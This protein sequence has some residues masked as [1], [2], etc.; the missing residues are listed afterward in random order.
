[1]SQI[2]RQNNLFAGEDFLKVFR[3]FKQ[4]NFTAYDYDTIRSALVDYIKEQFPED[5]NDYIESSEFIAII[6]LLSYLGTSLAFR[7]ELNSRENFL[8]TAERRESIIRLARML[9]YSPSRNQCARGLLKVFGV[10]TNEP[11][12][13]SMGNNLQ[14]TLVFWDDANNPNA[15]EQF[16]T[17]LNSSFVA[18]NPFGRPFKSG[19]IGSINTDLYQMNNSGLASIVYGAAVTLAD[20]SF[21]LEIVNPDF[22]DG[23]TFVERNPDPAN[24]FH[25]IYRN[26][27]NGLASNNTGFFMHFRQGKLENRDFQLDFPVENR[28]LPIDVN[29]I[30]NTDVYVQQI[31]DDGS[32][33]DHWD[34]VP[35]ISGSNI[36]FN[37]MDLSD[38][39]IY[40]VIT[41]TNDRIKLRFADGNFGE[42]P[43]GVFRAWY[44]KSANSYLTIRPENASNIQV[45]IPYVGRTGRTYFL[46]MYIGL[47]DTVNNSA[48]SETDE[49]I[50]I[51][52][53]QV[54][55]TQNRMVNAEDYNVFPLNKGNEIT[56]IHALNRTYSGHSRYISI[57]DPTGT[58]QNL[59][60]FGEDGY[61]YKEEEPDRLTVDVDNSTDFTSMIT[62]TLRQFLDNSR[63]T[64]WFY[65]I[66]YQ[67]FKELHPNDLTFINELIRWKTLPERAVGEQG[68]FLNPN[69]P[70]NLT[71]EQYILEALSLS[72]GNYSY[73]EPGAYLRFVN[74]NNPSELITAS[75]LSAINAGLPT[76]PDITQVGPVILS[77][78]IDNLWLLNDVLPA[79]RKDFDVVELSEIMAQI[80]LQTD[81]GLGYDA[82]QGLWYV[83]PPATIDLNSDFD[84]TTRGTS[85]DSSWVVYIDYEPSAGATPAS[86]TFVTRGIRYVFGSTQSVRFFFSPEQKAIDVQTGKSL[87]D[88]IDVLSI[89]NRADT[90]IWSYNSGSAVWVFNGLTIS[91]GQQMIMLRGRDNN[92]S[93]VQILHRNTISSVDYGSAFYN[94]EYGR[95]NFINGYVPVEGDV[96]EITYLDAT[97][98]GT[99]ISFD[100]SESFI[101]EDGHLDQTKVEIRPTDTDEDGVPDY[102]LSFTDIVNIDSDVIYFERFTDFD[103]YQYFRPWVTG[104]VDATVNAIVNGSA[105]TVNGFSVS[106]TGLY[107]FTD[108]A[109]LHAF[110]DS[111]ADITPLNTQEIFAQVLEGKIAHLLD[112][113]QFVVIPRVIATVALLS[114]QNNYDN[115]EV[116]NDYK[117]EIGRSYNLNTFETVDPFIFKWKHFAPRENRIDP[118]PSNI[119]DI[120]LLTS[121]YY[122]EVQKWKED[123]LGVDEFPEMPSSEDLAV[124]FG[125][126][127]EYKMISDE[128]I[129]KPAKYKI[130]FGTQAEPELRATFKVVKIP[131]VPVSDNEIKSRIVQAI[132]QYFDINNWD[133]GESFYYTELS[134]YIHQ[135][136]ANLV[137]TIVIVPTKEESQF[138]DLFQIKAEPD[139]LFI[140]TATVSNIQVVSS[141]TDYNLRT[142]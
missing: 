64:N 51:R 6:E 16:T 23:Q 27:N 57:N 3:S 109:S 118:S 136:L 106:E 81:F 44:R 79:F 77:R 98:L 104:Y 31:N 2:V 13:D 140:S 17:I 28:I 108:L 117:L 35:A 101:L 18:S 32:V 103:G 129:F 58:T 72:V 48:P 11:I 33:V 88:K 29:N 67:Q 41:E 80:D 69:T 4:V 38:R 97:A 134:A 70:T 132:D 55:Y 66:Y 113:E 75:V 141:L 128:I 5:F 30:N 85:S 138:G 74:E 125:D 65:D 53:P 46:N 10:Q 22:I 135:Q 119:I 62:V 83:V 127:N 131:T 114:G 1:M 86:Y 102:P 120:M 71:P 137:A 68:Y 139:E 116:T 91:N 124:Q 121:A 89:N 19:T 60:V 15:F 111:V 12:T 37:D 76:S 126:L 93:N 133:F 78:P 95:L 94:I 9:S 90:E 96:F 63:L 84:L 43:K 14:D 110:I 49:D 34:K 54:F 56:K 21:P 50:K 73:I 39:K 7:T 36:V 42:I 8:D 25:V 130:L 59:L 24:A 122:N 115:I 142:K 40:S 100:I 112:T 107:T 82:E 123:K 61:L 87:T 99:D 45:S 20:G 52:A 26:D 92:P 105:I 47:T